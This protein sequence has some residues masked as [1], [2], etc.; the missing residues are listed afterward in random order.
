VQIISPG[1]RR[2]SGSAD[3]RRALQR[4]CKNFYNFRGV[5]QISAVKLNANFGICRYLSRRGSVRPSKREDQVRVSCCAEKP[6][7]LLS[8][9]GDAAD[10]ER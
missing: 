8:S 10:S 4:I 6:H 5:L 3:L 1:L 2:C 9:M 7:L